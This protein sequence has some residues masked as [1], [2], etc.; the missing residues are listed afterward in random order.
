MNDMLEKKTKKT[1]IISKIF[2][3]DSRY[4]GMIIYASQFPF[5]LKKSIPDKSMMYFIIIFVTSL[6]FY[7]QN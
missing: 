4:M 3:S 5:L 1:A 7:K 6:Y 2:Q